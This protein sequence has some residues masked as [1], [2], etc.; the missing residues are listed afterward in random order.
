MPPSGSPRP[1]VVATSRPH[2]G[3]PRDDYTLED[4]SVDGDTVLLEIRYGGGCLE[5][6]FALVVGPDFM[7]SHPV[8][9]AATLAHDARNDRCRAIVGRRLRF[10]LTPLRELWERSYGPGPG[11]LILRL[12]D[13]RILY[14]F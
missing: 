8:Q 11:A 14:E 13:R 6:R 7:E 12:A 1:V 4:H 5:H 9:V 3:W 10:D 2:D